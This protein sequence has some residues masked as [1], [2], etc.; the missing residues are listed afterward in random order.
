MAVHNVFATCEKQATV[1]GE[2]Q[3]AA[4]RQCF[5][6]QKAS[7]EAQYPHAFDFL[8]D[9]WDFLVLMIG[10]YFL[11]MYVLS[12]KIDKLIAAAPAFY[13]FKKVGEEEAGGIENFGGEMKKF[14]KLAWNKPK[15]WLEKYVKENA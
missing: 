9:G 4:F 12:P 3:K 2:V 8:R 1:R 14:G 11:Y 10:L 7:V 5:E 13:P 6:T 15:D